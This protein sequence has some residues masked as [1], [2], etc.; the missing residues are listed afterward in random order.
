MTN[1]QFDRLT[2]DDLEIREDFIRRHIGPGQ[3]Q[4]REMLTTLGYPSIEALLQATV[5]ASIR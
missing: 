1:S 5:P 2:L 4:I 3:S